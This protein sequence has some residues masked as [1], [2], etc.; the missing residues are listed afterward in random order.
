MANSLFNTVVGK[1]AEEAARRQELIQ[2]KKGKT[3]E[4]K[5]CIDFFTTTKKG[6][7]GCLGGG[8]STMTIEGYIAKVQDRCKALNLRARAI[9]QLGIDESESASLID[10]VCLYNF[11]FNRKEINEGEIWI[12]FENNQVV[13][14]KYTVT[15]LFFNET[16]VYVYSNTFDML[17]DGVEEICR[18]IFYQDITCFETE[19]DVVEKIDISV[20]QGCLGGGESVAKNNYTRE[21]VQ[22]TVPGSGLSIPLRNAGTQ[23]QSIQA[24][25]ALIRERKFLK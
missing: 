23:I 1:G 11:D 5:D 13:T 21:Y 20:A 7:C 15:W 12:K 6:G 4:Q 24:A 8:N 14:S 2:M 3:S 16:Q 19:R 17:S 25:R 9:E 18:E 22:I 10:P